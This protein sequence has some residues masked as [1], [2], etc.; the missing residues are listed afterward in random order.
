LCREGEEEE[1]VVE[2]EEDGKWFKAHVKL[3]FWTLGQWQCC[4]AGTDK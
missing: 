3:P 2:E 4:V 1:V